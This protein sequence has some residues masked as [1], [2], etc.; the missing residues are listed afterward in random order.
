MAFPNGLRPYWLYPCKFHQL[1]VEVANE[2]IRRCSPFYLA[3]KDKIPPVRHG[4][5]GSRPACSVDIRVT[6]GWARKDE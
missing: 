3:D 2:G 4:A 6:N 5:M 1:P